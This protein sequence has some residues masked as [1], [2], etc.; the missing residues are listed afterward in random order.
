MYVSNNTHAPEALSALGW[1]TDTLRANSKAKEIF[2]VLNGVT[3]SW[4]AGSDGNQYNL[5]GSF[6][7][8]A[9]AF[10]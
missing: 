4:L 8:T 10:S 2:K 3:P 6:T 1:E 9:V 5:R 7:C